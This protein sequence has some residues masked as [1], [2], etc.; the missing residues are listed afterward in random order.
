MFAR[1]TQRSAYNSHDGT[2]NSKA[3]PSSQNVARDIG[4]SC[5]RPPC[6]PPEIETLFVWPKPSAV[7]FRFFCCT[8]RDM[9]LDRLLAPLAPEHLGVLALVYHV[10]D[11]PARPGAAREM[12]LAR[13]QQSFTEEQ[14]QTVLDRIVLHVPHWITDRASPA[15]SLQPRSR[16]NALLLPTEY[17]PAWNQGA[18]SLDGGVL[19]RWKLWPS[20]CVTFATGLRTGIVVFLR[21]ATCGA[22]YGGPWCWRHVHDERTFPAGHHK[23]FATQGS[24]EELG[25]AR[26]FFATPSMCWEVSLLQ[27]CLLLAA[28]GGVSWTALYVIYTTLWKSTA[29]DTQMAT[30]QHF[31]AFLE[32][33]VQVLVAHARFL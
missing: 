31:V 32:A 11:L 3:F 7:A 5:L 8:P 23:V 15:S 10:A 28:R 27:W 20:T 22:V 1:Q 16:L 26:W 24:T 25:R 33:A 30:R 18:C 19:F 2:S 4:A 29:V 14:I 13:F 17:V 9:A 21:C 6:E 12:L